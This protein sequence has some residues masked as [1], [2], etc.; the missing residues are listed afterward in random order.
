MA[1]YEHIEELVVGL[2]DLGE[3]GFMEPPDPDTKIVIENPEYPQ[4]VF[5]KLKSGRMSPHYVSTRDL[6]SFSKS[7]PISIEDQ[8][9][10]R[11]LVVDSFSGLLDEQNYDHLVGIP[12]AMTCLS[13]LIAQKR[14]ESVL[15]MRVGEKDYG[16]HKAI[17][18]HFALGETTV[19]LDNVIT[20]GASKLEVVEPLT[21][22]G[23]HIAHF[24]VLVD[25]EEGGKETLEAAGYSFAAV[26]GMNAI[27]DILADA[28]RITAQQK[29]WAEEYRRRMLGAE[30]NS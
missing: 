12:Q 25:R 19:A 24:D 2:Y 7:L 6:T 9:H 17:Q 16:A 21:E 20:D 1:E 4:E 13:G 29:G 30:N 8:I 26:V 11:D 5:R 23:I 27:T 18:G 15:W 14:G 28:D 10:I 22:A 3:I